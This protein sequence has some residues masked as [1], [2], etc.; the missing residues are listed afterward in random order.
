MKRGALI[1][2]AGV[3]VLQASSMPSAAIAQCNWNARARATMLADATTATSEHFGQITNVDCVNSRATRLEH[4]TLKNGVSVRQD[5]IAGG[6]AILGA[7]IGPVRFGYL[8]CPATSWTATTR[9]GTRFTGINFWHADDFENYLPDCFGGGGG[10]GGGC[11]LIPETQTWLI[12]PRGEPSFAAEQLRFGLERVDERPEARIYLEEWAVLSFDG[13]WPAVRGASTEAFGRRVGA[14]AHAFAPAEGGRSTVLVVESAEH[15]RNAVHI[16]TPALVPL[17]VRI[18]S[19]K[20]ASQEFLF[21]AEVGPAGVVEDVTLLGASPLQPLDSVRDAILAN[22]RLE[23][24]DARRHRS[25]VYARGVVTRDGRAV[26][27]HGLIVVARCC[28]ECCFDP[29]IGRICPC[30]PPI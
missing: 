19:E 9:F 5:E 15:P 29:E 16:P 17:D 11:P 1:L 22:L 30:G 24:A 6:P 10:G 20:A 21:R 12:G 7:S 14:S 3:G 25:A 26:V 23:Y 8:R 27:E 4:T 28:E 2:A 13:G 18:G